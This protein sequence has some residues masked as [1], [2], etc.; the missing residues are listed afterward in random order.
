MNCA[1]C[2]AIIRPRQQRLQCVT[3]GLAVHRTCTD[4][5]QDEY[6]RRVAGPSNDVYI[7]YGHR[8]LDLL[9]VVVL[10]HIVRYC[11]DDVATRR[12]LATVNSIMHH[13]ISSAVNNQHAA[14]RTRIQ[15]AG[16]KLFFRPALHD[17]L[18]HLLPMLA[19]SDLKQIAGRNSGP[20]VEVYRHIPDADTTV[21]EL[22]A[23]S[24]AGWYVIADVKWL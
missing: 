2:A 24:L 21:L 14:D 9:P 12:S 19:L 23:R 13:A 22:Q 20:M 1:I 16:Y 18:R 5:S 15:A 6:R 11:I 8:C 10:D 3:C 4:V 7:C 17:D